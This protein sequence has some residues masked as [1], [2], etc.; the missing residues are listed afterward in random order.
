MAALAPTRLG[1]APRL[2]ARPAARAMPRVVC[3]AADKKVAPEVV[4][5]AAAASVV[6]G[7]LQLAAVAAPEAA[8]A[9]AR[10]GGRVSSS[11]FAARRQGITPSAQRSGTVAGAS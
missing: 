10:S 5:T 11:G 6:V 8:L 9:A 7:A 4:R 2:A 3:Q 1:A